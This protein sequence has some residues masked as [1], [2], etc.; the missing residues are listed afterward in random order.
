MRYI[1]NDH[2]CTSHIEKSKKLKAISQD[3]MQKYREILLEKLR[4]VQPIAESDFLN[5]C[6]TKNE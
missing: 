5:F 6:N 2:L 3:E 4:Y 1:E